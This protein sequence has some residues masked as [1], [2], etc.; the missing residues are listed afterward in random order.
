MI[1]SNSIRCLAIQILQYEFLGPIKISEWGPPMEEVVYLLLSNIKDT[2]SIL[3]VGESQKTDER[4]FFTNNSKFKCWVSNVASEGDLY[5]S[6]FPMWNS[7]L[8]DRQKIVNKIIQK[9]KPICNLE[10]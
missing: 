10:G 3:Y 8:E 7:S 2:F 4:D 9:Y 6:I 5:L 1:V